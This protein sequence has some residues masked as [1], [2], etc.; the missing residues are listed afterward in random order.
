MKIQD[1][2]PEAYVSKGVQETHQASIAMTKEV[3]NILVKGIYKN[4]YL[5]VVREYVCNGRDGQVEA[6]INTPLEIHLPTSLEPWFAVKDN[7]VGMS[8]EMVTKT[9]MELGN[10]TKRERNDLIGAK[11]IGSK[12]FF[13]ISD[14]F[15]VNSIFDGVKTSYSIYMNKG[16]P[17]IAVLHQNETSEPNGVEVKCAIPSNRISDINKAAISF[18]SLFD[19]PYNLNVASIEDK[20]KYPEVAFEKE[21]DGFL[22]EIL[23]ETDSEL[24]DKVIMGG[25]GYDSNF[26]EYHSS[27]EYLVTVP[28]GAVDISPGREYTEENDNPEFVAKLKQVTELA[29]EQYYAEILSGLEGLTT[30]SEVI[31]YYKNQTN[32]AK[33]LLYNIY[34]KEYQNLDNVTS[35]KSRLKGWKHEF[36]GRNAAIEFTEVLGGNAVFMVKDKGSRLRERS[37]RLKDKLGV[38]V[39]YAVDYQ[40]KLLSEQ[41]FSELV[42][43]ASDIELESDKPKVRQKSSGVR[44]SHK[45]HVV[46]CV[47]KNK[48][49]KDRITKEEFKEIEYYLVK[50][51]YSTSN[52]VY[53]EGYLYIENY[54]PQM[55]QDC[56]VDKVYLLTER[57]TLWAKNAKL[58]VPEIKKELKKSL[59]DSSLLDQGYNSHAEDINQL[60]AVKGIPGRIKLKDRAVVPKWVKNYFNDEVSSYRSKAFD[61]VANMKKEYYKEKEDLLLSAPVLKFVDENDWQKKEVKDYIKFS[62]GKKYAK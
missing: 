11:G 30:I 60:R 23:A 8:K 42:Y 45:G 57:Q 47:T 50:S 53:V 18:F 20:I 6:G 39:V 41:F 40:F 54:G 58:F 61:I 37:E 16:I 22:V 44:A 52:S 43:F 5:A 1:N 7:G 35:Y 51:S 36:C 59:V 12:S 24:S 29:K 49:V 55:V 21:I 3:F 17:D 10:S 19:Y 38:E 25:V 34:I 26:L 4:P 15:S 62:G 31:N 28:I 48:L 2:A 13:S 14:S 56:N 46:H 9:F 33:V 32:K 27:E